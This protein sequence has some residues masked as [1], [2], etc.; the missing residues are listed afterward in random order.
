MLGCRMA[1]CGRYYGPEVG[2]NIQSQLL[3]VASY[4]QR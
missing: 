4:C 2:K 1:E 3:D